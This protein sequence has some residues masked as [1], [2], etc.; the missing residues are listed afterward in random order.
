MKA[1][2]WLVLLSMAVLLVGCQKA[3]PPLATPE[4]A[5]TGAESPGDLAA[6]PAAK[7]TPLSADRVTRLAP[8]EVHR[9]V[10]ADE[11]MLVCAYGSDDKFAAMKLEG[12]VPRSHFEEKLASIA[13]DKEIV[14]YCA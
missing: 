1:R 2:S 10:E 13:R 14:F 3:A 9:R 4:P 5:P 7:R 6:E 8:A 12:A 11:A